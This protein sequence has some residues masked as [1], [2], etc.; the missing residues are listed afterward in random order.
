MLHS[1][2]S[3]EWSL[4]VKEMNQAEAKFLVLFLKMLPFFL[5]THSLSPLPFLQSIKRKDKGR[6]NQKEK[7]KGR[8][9][10]NKELKKKK[11]QFWSGQNV[12]VL[13]I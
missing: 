5:S 3:D 8:Q 12:I 2:P 1:M 7:N 10:K 4:V 9:E 11:K 13:V 6:K